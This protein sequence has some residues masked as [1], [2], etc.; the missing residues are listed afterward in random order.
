MAKTR[1]PA[2][3][4]VTLEETEVS[5][6]PGQ[7][8]RAKTGQRIRWETPVQVEDEDPNQPMGKLIPMQP[9]TGP[10]NDPDVPS[11]FRASQENSVVPVPAIERQV[12]LPP[13]AEL[14]EGDFALSPVMKAKLNQPGLIQRQMTLCLHLLGIRLERLPKTLR[15][16][17]QRTAVRRFQEFLRSDDVD[18]LVRNLSALSNRIWSHEKIGAMA[19][20]LILPAAVLEVLLEASPM[21][22]LEDSP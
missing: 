21:T 8:E 11:S 6:D 10:L 2:P 17:L 1:K 15:E 18:L 16:D 12:G 22:L 9:A 4:P 19:M 7:I 14:S 20:G 5:M 3:M 13:L